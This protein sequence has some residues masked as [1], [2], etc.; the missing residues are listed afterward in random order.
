M[1]NFD[2]RGGNI[3]ITRLRLGLSDL[4]EHLYTHNLIDSPICSQCNLEP[5]STAHYLL[6]CPNFAIQRAVFLA[7]L[8]N[9]LD[10]DFLARL[11]D[12]D[13]VELFLFGNPEFPHESNMLLARMA[14]TYIIDSNRFQGR[15]F[16]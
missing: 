14:Q 9:V 8:L 4:A 16:H 1:H 3:F 13:I 15:A 11:K 5:E 7:D 2:Y 10:A 6:R 12:N